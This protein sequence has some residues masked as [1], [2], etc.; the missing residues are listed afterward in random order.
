LGEVVNTAFKLEAITTPMALTVSTNTASLLKDSFPLYKRPNRLI[1]G[2]DLTE[3]Y[4][5][6]YR[7]I[8]INSNI[9][10]QTY[11]K[12]LGVYFKNK[13]Y[14]ACK[15]LLAKIDVTLLEPEIASK[16]EIIRKICAGSKLKR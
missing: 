8:S 14:T 16:V 11:C 15:E 13:E 4:Y 3:S 5:V 10:L 1:K 6:I 12:Q 9:A 7:D 2:K